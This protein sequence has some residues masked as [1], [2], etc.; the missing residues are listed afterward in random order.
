MKKLITIDPLIIFFPPET[1]LFKKGKRLF[2][3]K[4]S[5]LLTKHENNQKLCNILSIINIICF[6]HQWSLNFEILVLQQNICDEQ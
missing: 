3:F 1:G 5:Q 2:L 6:H 4:I